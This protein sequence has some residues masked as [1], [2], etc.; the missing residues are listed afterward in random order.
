MGDAE[1][2]ADATARLRSFLSKDRFK[3]VLRYWSRG[4]SEEREVLRLNP[5]ATI[6]STRGWMVSMRRVL[7]KFYLMALCSPPTK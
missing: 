2:G 7:G 4:L 3:R 1:S 6:D 5:W